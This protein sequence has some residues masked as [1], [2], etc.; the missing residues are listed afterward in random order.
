[1]SSIENPQASNLVAGFKGT[2][3]RDFSY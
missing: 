2:M 3:S 1:M